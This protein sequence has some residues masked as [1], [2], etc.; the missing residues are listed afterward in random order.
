VQLALP[1]S[2]S[3][4]I[5]LH[6]ALLGWAFISFK[7]TPPSKPPEI[8]PV[9]VALI[10]PD[11]LVRLRKGSRTS[12]NL[13]TRPAKAT[14]ENKRK[15]ENK[16]IPKRAVAQPSKPKP[17]A[18]KPPQQPKK[19]EIAKKLASLK[20]PPKKG[21][22]PAELK[23]KAEAKKKAQAKKKAAAKKKAEAK[24][25]A[26]ERKRK[27][28]ELK[29]KQAKKKKNEFDPNKL[30]ALLNKIPEKAAAP[31][32]A[33]TKSDT[34]KKLPK[35]PQAGAEEG[36]DTRLT[37]SQLSM[38]GVMMK[39]AVREC[40]R[41]QTGMTGASSLIVDVEVKLNETG[42]IVGEPRVQNPRSGPVFRDAALNAIRALKQCAP[43]SDLPK[44][45]YKG[46]WDHMVVRFDPQRMF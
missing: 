30:Q 9:E 46:G 40:W 18:E 22:T 34:K 41:V 11:D 2:F 1:L 15:K 36:K 31:S 24:R 43:Y 3:L 26:A 32:G 25:K 20:P 8:R 28:E 10:T 23:K 17:K 29:R 7:T 27:A 5:L 19:D 6:S 38:I 14:Q 39:A 42:E 33:Q 44:K 13:E 21:P 16:K 12:K 45:L 37:A 35:G 4:S